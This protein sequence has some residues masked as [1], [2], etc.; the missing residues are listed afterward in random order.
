[1]ADKDKDI[2]EGASSPLNTYFVL[3][4]SSFALKIPSAMEYPGF[5]SLFIL[6]KVVS[7]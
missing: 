1:M 7:Q 4:I 2:T 5:F 3:V 6:C